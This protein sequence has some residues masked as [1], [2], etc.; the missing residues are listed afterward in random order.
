MVVFA[1]Y[2]NAG[3]SKNDVWA[4][5]FGG[6][7]PTLVSLVWARPFTDRVEIAWQVDASAVASAAVERREET[8]AWQTQAT[9]APDGVGRVSIVD[10]AVLPGTRYDYR[11]GFDRA[12][13]RSYSAETWVDVP[14]AA[15]FALLGG[16]PNPSSGRLS[17][18]FTLPGAGPAQLELLDVSGRR[19]VA[20]EVGSLGAGAH[21]VD[22]TPQRPLAPGVYLLRL[23]R[24]GRTAT[25][26]AAVVH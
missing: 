9:V 4:L 17:A 8:S 21:N 7:T 14:A 5:G 16:R 13:G 10:R 20:R 26:R 1:G 24:E 18:W 2:D 12:G 11:L 22:L 25:A 15:A 19:I 6:P 23:T 3:A